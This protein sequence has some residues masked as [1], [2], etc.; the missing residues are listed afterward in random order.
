MLCLVF[1][2]KLAGNG[3]YPQLTP[4]IEVKVK[5]KLNSLTFCSRN[6][7]NTVA[8]HAARKYSRKVKGRYVPGVVLLYQCERGDK[9]F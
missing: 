8:D 1:K 3:H 4:T 2:L 7:R 9:Q 5:K 6:I